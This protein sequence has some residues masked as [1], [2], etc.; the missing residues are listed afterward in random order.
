MKI[1]SLKMLPMLLLTILTI[2]VGSASAQWGTSQYPNSGISRFRWE[3]IVDGTTFIYIQGRQ[4]RVET[5]SGLP[6]QRQRY[7]FTDPL[8]RASVQLGLEVFNGRG[9]VRLT[10]EP[11]SSNGFTAVV[12][13]ED[14]SG[15]RDT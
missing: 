8:P 12:R 3:G 14:N 11:R 15:G 2:L 5:R 1:N 4:V 7:N 10:E 9:R 6:V 13:I